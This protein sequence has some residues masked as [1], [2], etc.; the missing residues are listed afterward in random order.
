MPARILGWSGGEGMAA[1]GL[2]AEGR[3]PK[4]EGLAVWR[5]GRVIADWADTTGV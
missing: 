4:D 3:R 1:A 2:K 5:V